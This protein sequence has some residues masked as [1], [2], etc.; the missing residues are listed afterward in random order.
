MKLDIFTKLKAKA[1]AHKL[2]SCLVGAALAAAI[3]GGGWLGWQEYQKRQTAAYA[4]EKIKQALQPADPNK[5]AHMV[6]FNVLGKELSQAIM[7]AFPFYM[8]G[9]NQERDI[10][11]KLQTGFLQR[12]LEKE[13]TGSQFPEDAS[14]RAKL[15]K[16]LRLLPDDFVSQLV[17][18]L[19][20]RA[21][22]GT[23][24]LAVS[25]FTHP[26]LGQTYNLNMEMRKTPGGWQ[27]THLLNARE[28]AGQFREAMLKRFI[29]LREVVE[30][31]NDDTEKQMNELM[32]IQSCT[33][34]VGRLSSGDTVLLVIHAIARNKGDTQV[35]NFNLSTFITN[36]AGAIIAHRY[37]NAAKPVPP[38][39]DFNQ[40]WTMELEGS[41]PLAK[42]LLANAPLACR[43]RWQ[44]LSL[45]KPKVYHIEEVPNPDFPC[46]I[47]GHNHPDGFCQLP[48]FKY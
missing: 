39:E 21:S 23:T 28:L 45:A 12:L 37:L 14:E 16:P 17:G 7:E 9:S 8:A 38:G 27:I 22:D 33:A 15:E 46:Q 20:T 36:R 47:A 3:A 30:K 32:P 2:A 48:V 41:D 35:N 31:K 43:A 11:H 4:V 1:A 10:S 18:N 24:A 6:D 19:Q 13:S 25:S 5:L 42:T 34:N 26:Q 40:R 29:A 44:T